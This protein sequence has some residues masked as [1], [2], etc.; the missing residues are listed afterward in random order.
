M[1]ATSDGSDVCV[2]RPRGRGRRSAYLRGPPSRSSSR[3][4]HRAPPGPPAD[5]R[6]RGRVG[7][8]G[9]RGTDPGLRDAARRGA[10][11]SARGGPELGAR[12]RHAL[13][14]RTVVSAVAPLAHCVSGERQSQRATVVRPMQAIRWRHSRGRDG[15]TAA[16]RQFRRV[17]RVVVQ[18]PGGV[19][20]PS[21]C[22]RPR[23]SRSDQCST[24]LPARMR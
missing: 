12:A 6:A 16:A 11:T 5:R 18:P 7:S 14:A 21:C 17:R 15:V 4:S 24:I 20:T 1:R 22:I 3:S 19:T 13:I 10:D 23:W 9:Q 2:P 8:H